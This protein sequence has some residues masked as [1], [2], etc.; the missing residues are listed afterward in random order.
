MLDYS[1]EMLDYNAEM[2]EMVDYSSE[3]VDDSADD[4]ASL[5]PPQRQIRHRRV[6][7]RLQLQCLRDLEEETPS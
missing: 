5:R 1:A 2:L 3:M 6:H 4:R 7:W